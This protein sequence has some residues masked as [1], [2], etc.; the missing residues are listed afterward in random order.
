MARKT[1][2]DQ[3]G[4]DAAGPGPGSQQ[5]EQQQPQRKSLLPK[6][7][8]RLQQQVTGRQDVPLP[9][10]G[11]NVTLRDLTRE[12]KRHLEES[13]AESD[14]PS[15]SADD[16]GE[17]IQRPVSGWMGRP[18]PRKYA[19]GTNYLSPEELEQEVQA[20]NVVAFSDLN[21][22]IKQLQPWE[23]KMLF[24][25]VLADYTKNRM[26]VELDTSESESGV[27]DSSGGSSSS[28]HR[29]GPG[30]LVSLWDLY[31]YVHHN[32]ELEALAKSHRHIV[33]GN[34][35]EGSGEG[36]R[37]PPHMAPFTGEPGNP[38]AMDLPPDVVKELPWVLV[39]K[40]DMWKRRPTRWLKGLDGKR[41]FNYGVYVHEDLAHAVLGPKYAGLNPQRVAASEDYW[42]DVLRVGPQLGM[43]YMVAA[44]RD[45]PLAEA[46]KSWG[47]KLSNRLHARGALPDGSTPPRGLHALSEMLS[48]SVLH[49]QTRLLTDGGTH[50]RAGSTLF[51]TTLPKGNVVLHAM[52]ADPVATR[53]YYSLGS[54]K[55]EAVSGALGSL[56]LGGPPCRLDQEPPLD[57]Q[58][59]RQAPRNILM[60]AQ[61]VKMG[62]HT[63]R[64]GVKPPPT[65][66]GSAIFKLPP[67]GGDKHSKQAPADSPPS[68]VSGISQ[69]VAQMQLLRVFQEAAA[70]AQAAAPP[71][72]GA[73]AAAARRRAAEQ[74]LQ[75]GL[76]Q[77]GVDVQGLSLLRGDGDAV[78][79]LVQQEGGNGGSP[80]AE[81]GMH[82]GHLMQAL[83]QAH[84]GQQQQQQDVSMFG[85]AEPLS[86]APQA[87]QLHG[88]E[89][90]ESK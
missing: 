62:A 61:G 77:L 76:G 1:A 23:Q 22:S 81:G 11:A 16:E 87:Q 6:S 53:E 85:A 66:L 47:D 4:E 34:T 68:L 12:T 83:A 35:P 39:A 51:I 36:R 32:P 26:F 41:D 7:W 70:A 79:P 40:G 20:G 43:S 52:T 90:V 46:S 8:Q 65:M 57:D 27:E 44:A 58:V 33:D 29:K 37:V 14:V 54:F 2:A 13:G 21:E 38:Y 82:Q 5:Q 25:E 50:V 9:S 72:P 15:S 71:G 28:S 31:R 49:S 89:V 48:P 74:V 60:A 80:H 19:A 78:G 86:E 64:T 63:Q 84:V 73:E 75:H 30:N 17:G 69:D 56:F 67:L 3:S 45:L 10:S 55:D 88:R 18:D 59:L 42:Q 24:F